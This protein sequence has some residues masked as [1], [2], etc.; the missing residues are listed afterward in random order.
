MQ[1]PRHGDLLSKSNKSPKPFSVPSCILATV[2]T[3]KATAPLP[4]QSPSSLLMAPTPLSGDP[5]QMTASGNSGAIE[6]GHSLP[7][8]KETS[9][10]LKRF[11]PSLRPHRAILLLNAKVSPIP[12]RRE[13]GK[14]REKQ[15]KRR[16]GAGEGHS[17]RHFGFP[18][19][20]A[21]PVQ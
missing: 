7:L 18:E 10:L 15:K 8:N 2:S 16:G 20:K 21:E 17:D 1:F 11:P 19:L 13:G 14:E 12:L 5:L 9:T 3:E 4:N 6:K